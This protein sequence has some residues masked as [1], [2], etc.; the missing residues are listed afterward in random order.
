ML[1][2]EQDEIKR[3]LHG[4]YIGPTKAIWRLFEFSTHGEEPH[5]MHL[6]LHLPNEQPIYFS[7]RE[8]P[9]ILHQR[10]DSS[11]TTLIAYFKFNSN[12]ADGR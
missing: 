9:A 4:R 11:L 5:V 7:E 8:D 10:M 1:D 12:R 2:S 6:A 3:Y